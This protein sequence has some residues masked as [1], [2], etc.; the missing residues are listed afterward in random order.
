MP[1]ARNKNKSSKQ[2]KPVFH[3][4]CE[5]LKTEPYYINSYINHYH[6]E[7]R[8]VLVVEDNN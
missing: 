6:P 8:D 3:I 1:K 7:R 5:G 2:V 4:F